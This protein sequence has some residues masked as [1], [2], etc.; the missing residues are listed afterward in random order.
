MGARSLQHRKQEGQGKKGY[1]G[2]PNFAGG[3]ICHSRTTDRAP[4]TVGPV[5]GAK[6]TAVGRQVHPTI[7]RG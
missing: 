4:I 3:G 7:W 2:N 1:L 6:D 5:P